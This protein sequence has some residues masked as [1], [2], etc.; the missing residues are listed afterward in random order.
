MAVA[1]SAG[2]G[3]CGNIP[4]PPRD[5]WRIR[6]FPPPCKCFGVFA[7]ALCRS[8]LRSA[9]G[10]VVGV[11]RRGLGRKVGALLINRESNEKGEPISK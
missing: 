2:V 8:I 4:P 10:V 9:I 5:V 1:S 3:S 6:H 11:S 7:V